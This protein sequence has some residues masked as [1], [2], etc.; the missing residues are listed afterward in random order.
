MLSKASQKL[1]KR[2]TEFTAD[3]KY[4]GWNWK[5]KISEFTDSNRNFLK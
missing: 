4:T 2:K 3:K 5:K 1:K